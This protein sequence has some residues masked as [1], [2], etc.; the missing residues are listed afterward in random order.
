[1]L[2]A[3]SGWTPKWEDGC[4]NWGAGERYNENVDAFVHGLRAVSAELSA[5][6]KGKGKGKE[7]EGMGEEV[8]LVIMVE[9]AE[10]LKD[11]LPD[12]VVP[13]TRLAE[14]VSCFHRVLLSLSS[15]MHASEVSRM[16]L[17]IILWDEIMDY[18]P[19]HYRPTSSIYGLLYNVQSR[20]ILIC[21]L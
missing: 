13:L 4:E 9:R 7:Q 12:L 15:S 20:D 17:S 16:V 2:N 5:S 18:N 6:G 3:L 8:R 10:R 1:V 21:S 19:F 14:L 11:N